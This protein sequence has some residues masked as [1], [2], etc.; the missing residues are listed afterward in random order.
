MSAADSTSSV[1]AASGPADAVGRGIVDC[2]VHPTIPAGLGT[3]AEYMPRAWR[4]RMGIGKK[5]AYA[6][7]Q[8]P[9]LTM[10]VNTAGAVR[11]D[12][13]TSTMPPASDPAFVAAQLLDQHDISRAVLTTNQMVGLGG[14]PDPDVAAAI[15]AAHNEWL[16]EHWLQFDPRYRGNL[17]VAPQDPA[18]AAREI[19]R[20]ADRGGF[21]SVFVPLFNLAM[22]ERHFYPIYEAAQR[23]GL[24]VSTHPSGTEGEYS[25]GPSMA[26]PPT[27]YLEWHSLLGQA[28]QSNVASLICQGVFERFPELNVVLVEGGFAWAAELMWGLDRNWKG[29]RD[30]VPWLRRAPSEY[31]VEH[32]RFTSQPFIEPAR[33]E[34]VGQILDMVVA[35]RTLLFSSDYPHWDFDDPHRALVGVDADLRRAI[36]VDNP[37]RVFGDRLK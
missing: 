17:V 25:R 21:V 20:M 31:L 23:H 11:E 13:M 35:E 10:Y 4:A 33:R 27:Y 32:I 1:A 24:P 3:L 28:Q 5:V 7:V 9:T 8:L 29:L 14:L 37:W 30:E 6:E 22:G 15:A 19:D 12:A 18:L 26:M 16:H 2:D 36:C 34:Q